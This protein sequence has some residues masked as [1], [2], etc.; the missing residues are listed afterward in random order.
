MTN[1]YSLGHVA[2][3]GASLALVAA[4]AIVRLFAGAW[5]LYAAGLPA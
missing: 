5:L 4:D 1:T 2:Q 3:Q